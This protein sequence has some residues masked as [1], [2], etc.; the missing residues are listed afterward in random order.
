MGF[1]AAQCRNPPC[2]TLPGGFSKPTQLANYS[3]SGIGDLNYDWHLRGIVINQ[4]AM[5]ENIVSQ[6]MTHP[7]LDQM[8]E[9]KSALAR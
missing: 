4:L 3:W 8:L 1:L 9:T 6:E 5:G 2:L 7:H